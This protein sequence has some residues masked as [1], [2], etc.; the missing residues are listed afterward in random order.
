MTFD[1]TLADRLQADYADRINGRFVKHSVTFTSAHG[2]YSVRPAQLD[3]AIEKYLPA[4]PAS[5]R[6][7][8]ADQSSGDIDWSDVVDVSS[9]LIVLAFLTCPF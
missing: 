4:S 1:P 6:A 5:L 2:D 8:L 3:W 9:L 7:T